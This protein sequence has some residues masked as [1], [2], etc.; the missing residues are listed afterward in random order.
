MIDRKTVLLNYI[1]NWDPEE[2]TAQR[3]LDTCLELHKISYPKKSCIKF[4]IHPKDPAVGYADR[5]N[6]ISIKK[7]IIACDS[8]GNCIVRINK[9]NEKTEWKICPIGKLEKGTTSR[10]LD[11]IKNHK[12]LLLFAGFHGIVQIIGQVYLV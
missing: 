1:G 8:Q 2:H 6:R 7:D 3:L 4:S 9:K 10:L 11:K 5:I 12:N